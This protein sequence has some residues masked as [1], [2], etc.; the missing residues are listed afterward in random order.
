MTRKID[1]FDTTLRD[2]EQSPGASMN[3]EEKLV[4]ARQLLRL[5]VD[6]IEAG[7]PISSPGDFESVRRISELAGDNAVVCGL[8]RAI[9]KDIEVCAD[10][11][12]YAKRPRIHTGIGVSPSHMRDKLR[13][14]EEECLERAVHAVAFA[15]TF[16]DDVQFY[17]ED[18]GR[19]DFAFLAKVIEAVIAAGA[20]VVNIPDTTGYSL[21]WDFGDRIKY[22][23]DHVKG[24]DDVTISVHCHN[25]LGM[26]TALSLAGV[27]N[28]ATQIECTINGLGERAGNTAMEEVVMG[29]RMHGDEL[30]AHTDINTD[31]TSES[32]C[33][34]GMDLAAACG[35]CCDG[36][37]VGKNKVNLLGE[38]LHIIGA[39]SI[40]PPEYGVAE[41][42]GAHLH[43]VWE[44]RERGLEAV[45]A[46]I[47]PAL[48]G[49]QVHISFD[50]DVLDPAEFTATGYNIPEGLAVAEVERVLSAVLDTGR[51]CSFE[52]VEYNPA[53]D[54]GK[55]DLNTLMGILKMVSEKLK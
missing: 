1:I 16:V 10:A 14:T 22:L 11:L 7:F 28:G 13:I 48:E 30:D 38:N 35:L 15:K 18:A 23:V 41:R 6:V 2:G 33:I 34:H 49:K 36:L 47:L 24:I 37:T 51:A 20:T 19:S 5:N 8:T 46:D 31:Q 43:T 40:D 50:V 9:D 54:P 45:L 4:V 39:R 12:K 25:D 3:T 21:P 26:A 52:C 29:I 17:A 32:G 53:M 27:R 44:V 42:A 55:K